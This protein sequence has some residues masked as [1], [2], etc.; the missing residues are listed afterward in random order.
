MNTNNLVEKLTSRMFRKVDDAVWDMTTGIIGLKRNDSVYSLTGTS[1]KD[2]QITENLFASLSVPVPAFAQQIPLA[3][4][5]FGDLV[6]GDKAALGWVIKTTPRTVTVMTPHGTTSTLTP[7]KVQMFGTGGDTLLVLRSLISMAGGQDGLMGMQSSML[8]MLMLM[9][10]KA[11]DNML[12]TMLMMQMFSGN[13]GGANPM[14]SMNPMMLMM[15]M[16][17]GKDFF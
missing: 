17:K 3:Q 13:A 1:D 2:A 8:P 10:D 15:L 9:G 11:D 14:S 4:V 5:A 16:G 7:R 6:Y 12:Q